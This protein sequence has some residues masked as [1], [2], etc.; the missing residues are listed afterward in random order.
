[1]TAQWLMKACRKF[2]VRYFILHILTCVN[3]PGTYAQDVWTIKSIYIDGR[4]PSSVNMHWRR[5]AV[6]DIPEDE[7]KFDKWLE[8]RWVEKDVLLEYYEKNGCFPFDEEVITE[9]EPVP[10]GAGITKPVTAT[11]F[12]ETSVRPGSFLE[13]IQIYIPTL[14]GALVLHLIWRLWNWLLIALSIRAKS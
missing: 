9:Y 5:F 8:Q 10:N 13:V 11:N 6:A 7:A 3:R 2:T 1:M 14:A 12:L 4:G